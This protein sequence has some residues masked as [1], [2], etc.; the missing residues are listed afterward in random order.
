VET[1]RSRGDELSNIR[2]W[3]CAYHVESSGVEERDEEDEE[4]EE[5][6]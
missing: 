5:R 6:R 2:D 1:T 4:E 3:L